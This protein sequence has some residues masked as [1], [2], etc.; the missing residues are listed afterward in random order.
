MAT[1]ESDSSFD[2]SPMLCMTCGKLRTHR[3]WL[4][5]ESQ[6]DAKTLT[7]YIS[8]VVCIH[9]DVSSG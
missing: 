7:S 6:T 4:V 1:R 8:T 9:L 3:C 5:H 2:A